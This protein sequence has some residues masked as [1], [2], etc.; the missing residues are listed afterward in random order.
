MARHL[1]PFSAVK[2]F[3]AA[4]RHGSFAKAAQ[5]LDVTSTAISQHVKGLE[6]W[7]GKDLFSRRSNG[8]A[9]THEGA[10]LLADVTQI[11]D[12]IADLLPKAQVQSIKK[13][14]LTV[15]ALP[16][17]AECWLATRL[18]DFLAQNPDIEINIR[19]ED[20]LASLEKDPKLDFAIRHAMGDQQG[21]A[22]ELLLQD[23]L[24]PVST[25]YYRDLLGLTETGNWQKA[26]LL[27]ERQWASD[28]QIWSDTHPDLKL[29]WQSGQ[30]FSSYAMA[31]QAAKDSLGI[32]MGHPALIAKEL[33]T[34]ELIPL[35][36]TPLPASRHFLLLRHRGHSQPAA[37]Q[38]R[39]WL[40]ATARG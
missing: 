32:L 29:D 40:L 33:Q 24:M 37:I 18:P 35:A 38:F 20:H 3:E 11:L 17:F 30:R 5:E 27:H 6:N 23:A 2:A 26:T 25:P 31:L 9:L 34:G 28:W 21:A 16:A 39:S 10:T 1:P 13:T 36:Q 7:L 14:S 8:V 15:S 22:S 19:A 12:Q 4:A